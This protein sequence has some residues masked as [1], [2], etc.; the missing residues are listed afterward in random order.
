VQPP[1]NGV[2]HMSTTVAPVYLK[3]YK[4]KLFLWQ[5]SNI[6]F[7]FAASKHS[8]GTCPL[9]EAAFFVPYIY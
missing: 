4:K 9:P 5:L 8:C 6:F 1:E 3:N 2:V 7:I